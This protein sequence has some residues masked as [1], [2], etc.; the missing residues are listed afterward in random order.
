MIFFDETKSGR[1]RHLSGLMRVNRRLREE[2]GDA[3]TPVAW[4]KWDRQ[5]EPTDWFFTTEIFDG[6]ERKGWAEFIERPP[7]RIAAVFSDA[8]PL[9][10]P[11]ITWPHS[12]AR[13]PRYMSELARFDHVFAVSEE[14]RRLLIDFWA[15]QGGQPARAQVSVLPL[16]ADF[17]A[18]PR[19]PAPPVLPPPLLLAVG[20]VEPRKNQAFLAEVADALWAQGQNFELHVVGR[21]NPHFGRPIA[22]QLTALA[23]R[24]PGLHFHEAASD[25]ALA[26]VL[27]R[28]RAV[29]FPTLAEGCGLPVLAAMWR[30]VPCVCSDLPVLRE[31]TA[32]GGCLNLPLNDHAAWLQGLR[33]ILTEEAIW[34]D[35]A[36]TAATRPLPTW[37]ESAAVVRRQLADA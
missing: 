24:R 17:D 9:Q 5:A 16:G 6:E 8:I 30:G 28:T 4:K 23:R 1:A 27:A 2:F 12:V 15:W 32:G 37:A 18:S 29:V 20:I 34:R 22:R 21:I 14:T 7:C 3:V 19:Q 36:H 11:T 26:A 33:A 10:H 31:N 35:L 13:H 25:A